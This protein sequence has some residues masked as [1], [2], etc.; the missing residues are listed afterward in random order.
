MILVTGGT[1]FIG[2]NLVA[3]LSDAGA[4]I[5]VSDTFGNEEKWR[6]VAKH[7]VDEWV[8]PS[9]LENFLELRGSEIEGVY[10]MGAISAT[11]ETD[12][13]LIVE[14]NIR[15]SQSIWRW[16]A[17]HAVPLVYASSAAAYGDGSLGFDDSEDPDH[18]ARLRP[19]NAYGWSKLTFDRW[20]VRQSAVGQAP[21]HWYGVRFFNVYGPNEYHKGPMKSVV[22]KAYPGAATGEP[23][24]LF[25]SHHPD[26]EDGGQQRDF[27]H[28][29]DCV[30]VL[31][32]LSET[33]PASGIYNVGS[34]RAQS[35]LELMRALF[36]AVGRELSV[37]WVDTPVEI[38]AKYQYFTEAQMSK[39]R[40]A[41]Y[42]RPFKDVSHGVRDYV[43]R[44][45]A[46]DDPYR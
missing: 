13:D 15:L 17:E 30:D 40:A 18:L 29:S 25:R 44:Y 21:P 8:A 34:G 22:A 39:L 45:L 35:W 20:A 24:T 41:G 2:S 7:T 43:D 26:Y 27:V 19:L 14:T 32:W 33:R 12:V 31:S 11:T 10:H 5:A 16:C 37:S 1:G 42:E 46:T 3:G 38:R 23:V 28:V 36:D 9:G 4:S 6:N